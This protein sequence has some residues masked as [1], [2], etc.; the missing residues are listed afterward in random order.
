MIKERIQRWLCVD[1]L[2][3]QRAIDRMNTDRAIDDL[4]AEYMSLRSDVVSLA[5][6]VAKQKSTKSTIVDQ[7][8]QDHSDPHMG[9]Q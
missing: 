8:R 1:R 7:L 4:R 9:A 3:T 2:A 5:L 6:E